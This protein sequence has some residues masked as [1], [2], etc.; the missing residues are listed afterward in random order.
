MLENLN[1]GDRRMKKTR[2]GRGAGTSRM[3]KK[4]RDIKTRRKKNPCKL[5]KQ[6]SVKSSGARRGSQAEGSMSRVGPGETVL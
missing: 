6:R 3:E 4:K 2:G 1:F 5:G